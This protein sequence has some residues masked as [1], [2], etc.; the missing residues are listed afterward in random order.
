MET[1]SENRRNFI[2]KTVVAGSGLLVLNSAKVF[3]ANDRMNVAMITAYGRA[4][5]HYS[6]LKTENVVAV[7]D[8][9]KSQIPFALKE[10]PDAKVYEDWRKCLDHPGL[11]AI[12][13]CTTDF[14]HSFVANWALNRN[15]HIYLEKPLAI[16]VQEARTVRANY[17]KR[18]DKLATQVGMQRHAYPNFNRIH[19]AVRDGAIGELKEACAWGNRQIRRDG[20]YPEEKPIPDDINWDLWLGP[21]PYHPYNS[22][23]VN[24]KAEAG[25][26]Q[27]N[28]FWDF[29]IGQM[30]DMGS[31]TMDLLWNVID[32]EQPTSVESTTPEKLNPEVTPVELTSHFKFPANKWRD[33]IDV[34]WYQGGAMPKSP[35]DWIDLNKI[36]HGAMFKGDKGVLISDFR[37]HLIIP[38]EDID[39]MSHFHPRPAEKAIP[40]LGHFQSQWI[41]ACKNGKPAETAC[42]FEYSANMIEAMCLG[43][44]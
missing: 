32:A 34:T 4:R 42:N 2:K 20:Y 18:K 39:S 9:K 33:E 16:T 23:Y 26:L 3:G 22:R 29:G 25:C 27:W 6:S 28:M 35:S 44:A 40:D 21:S 7:C 10:F 36:G 30:G 8:V 24:T 41:N 37:K 11:D 38:N 17:L 5:A 1:N 13:C 15:Y 19:E 31:H 43:L 12:V 14:T